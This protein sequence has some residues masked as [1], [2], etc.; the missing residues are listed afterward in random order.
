MEPAG[1]EV[2]GGRHPCAP[3][4]GRW[5]AAALVP[6]LV[7]APILA[8][9]PGPLSAAVQEGGLP[10][11]D[12]FPADTT[13]PDTTG[14]LPHPELVVRALRTSVAAD[15]LPY[16]VSVRRPSLRAPT[17]GLTLA[18]QLRAV[19]GL[20]V[21][22]R[23]NDA[24]GD[25]IIVRGFGARAQFGVRGVHVLVDGIPATMPDGQTTLNHLDLT[26]LERAEVLRGPAAAVHGNAA[27]GVVL[28]STRPPP[29]AGVWQEVGVAAGSEGLLRLRST[30]A[31]GRERG[32]WLASFTREERDGFRP[33]S[34]TER[35][36]L[37]GRFHAP[38]AGGFL[39]A[40]AHGVDYD[41]ENPGSLT[42][43][44]YAADPHQ[45]QGYNV[46]QRTGEKGRHGQVG[47]GW[48]RPL[49]GARLET[50][51]YALVR[52]L[53]NPIP[54]SIIDLQRR[55]GGARVLIGTGDPDA[56]R[57][58]WA[59][60]LDGAVQGDDRR[61]FENEGGQRGA[62]TLDQTER[63]TNVAVHGQ[64]I[65]PVLDRL[66]LLLA[67][68]YDRIGF[69]ADD[70]LVTPE[71]PDDSGERGMD[72][73]SPTAGLR[74][75]LAPALSVFGNVATAFETPTTTE[76]VNRP[77]GSGGFNQAL[78]P[79]R[80]VSYEAGVRAT[81]RRALRVEASAYH[82]RVTDALVPFEVASAP[83]RQ[84]FRNAGGAVHEGLE[85]LAELALERVDLVAAYSRTHAEFSAYQVE[86]RSF[87][88]LRVPGVRPWTSAVLVSARPTGTLLIEADYQAVGEMAADDANEA[89]APG[90]QLVGLRLSARG[91]ALGRLGVEPYL[92]VDNILDE[93]YL[94]SV[95][96]NAFGGR[97]F[98]PGPGRSGYLGFRL[99]VDI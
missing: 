8:L 39:R 96:P 70:R 78:E 92:G 54:P 83:G 27:G 46:A 60:G 49:G 89:W 10:R 15:R 94:T 19:P 86:G 48:E 28:L 13:R 97:F 34:A 62:L 71:N 40:V 2:R 79:Q 26:L 23:Y 98:E 32:G 4:R 84:Y 21:H 61:N 25:R 88:G 91:V 35:S 67:A 77:D 75:A 64:A 74:L 85:L 41:A 9:L 68:R 58:A 12:T 1:R 20:Q 59:V 16:A 29:A 5:L 14:A 51:V 93:T 99:A 56:G 80:T 53:D 52:G 17:A 38:L 63:V 6:T 24:M 36:Q 18:S 55:A 42:L 66:D 43:E 33:H 22:S 44:Q 47:V 73:L 65:L 3:G 82:A 69:A 37:T 87:D 81:F 72:A 45:A 30:T 31:G 7:L 50:T 95:V 57:V 90:Y 76:L 11:P